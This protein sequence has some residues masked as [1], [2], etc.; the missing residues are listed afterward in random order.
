M[1]ES[2]KAVGFSRY[3]LQSAVQSAEDNPPASAGAG[4]LDRELSHSSDNPF[5][6]SQSMSDLTPERHPILTCALEFLRMRITFLLTSRVCSGMS[7]RAPR[8]L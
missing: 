5:G 1:A 3:S 4:H 6:F 8:R 7:F 2:V